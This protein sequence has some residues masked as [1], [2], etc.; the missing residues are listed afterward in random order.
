MALAAAARSRLN[1][2]KLETEVKKARED[3]NR[4]L[5][6]HHDGGAMVGHGFAQL[7]AWPKGLEIDTKSLRIAPTDPNHFW[8]ASRQTFG[9]RTDVNSKVQSFKQFVHLMIRH[10]VCVC[11][12]VTETG[13]LPVTRDYNPRQSGM[14]LYVSRD[15]NLSLVPPAQQVCDPLRGHDGGRDSD[16]DRLLKPADVALQCVYQQWRHLASWVNTDTIGP[17]S[18]VNHGW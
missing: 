18:V 6:S 15:R 7:S 16:D 10:R 9:E 11:V 12:C 17:Q 4:H 5:S 14:V 8:N 13:C 1:R 2:S 3:V